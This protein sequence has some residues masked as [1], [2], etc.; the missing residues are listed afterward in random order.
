MRTSSARMLSTA[1]VALCLVGGTAQAQGR[2]RGNGKV[3]PGLAKVPPG[4]AK[5]GGLPPGQAKKIY[6]ADD[7]VGVLRDI[8]GQHGYTVVRTANNGESRYVY[9]RLRN[10]TIRRAIV[11]PGPD[12]LAFRNVPDA[13]LREVLARL[14]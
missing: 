11:T 5:K 8:F 13:L 9:Y 10:G 7:G 12:R 2:G 3:P 14:Y 6:R 1:L 4:L